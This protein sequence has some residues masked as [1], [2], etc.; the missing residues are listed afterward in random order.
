LNEP[1][2]MHFLPLK[3]L[4]AQLKMLFRIVTIRIF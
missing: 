2:N 1:Q 4:A 3:K